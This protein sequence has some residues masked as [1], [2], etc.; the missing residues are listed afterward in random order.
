MWT[1]VDWDHFGTEIWG[2][3]TFAKELCNCGGCFD[4]LIR[5]SIFLVMGGFRV[6][7]SQ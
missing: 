6:A 7:D 2:K 3:P 4:L 5:G 1:G